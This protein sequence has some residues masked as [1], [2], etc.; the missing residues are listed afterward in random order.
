MLN[1]YYLGIGVEIISGFI[2]T[3]LAN[4][5]DR[6]MQE[7]LE[8]SK[9]NPFFAF[10]PPIP[11]AFPEASSITFLDAKRSSI[12]STVSHKNSTFLL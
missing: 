6:S 7:K 5:N 8:G 3:F 2:S 9:Q 4:S 12:F 11:V 1:T 10:R